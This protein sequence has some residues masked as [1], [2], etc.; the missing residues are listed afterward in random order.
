VLILPLI[1]VPGR[2]V[3]A[4]AAAATGAVVPAP[5]VS[6][7]ATGVLTAMRIAKLKL[8]AGVVAAACLVGVGG[9]GAYSA[10]AQPPAPVPGL[11]TGQ[12]PAPAAERRVVTAEAD[13]L[14]AFPELTP[15]GLEDLVM[16]CPRL[17]GPADEPPAAAKDD[18]L[19]QLQVA[20]VNA[21]RDGL[22]LQLARWQA[23][24]FDGSATGDVYALA[25]RAAEAAADLHTG[26]NGVVE[27]ARVRPWFEERVRVA[28]W[29]ELIVV[30]RVRA[31]AAQ[32]DTIAVARTSRLDAEIAL[33]RLLERERQG[34]RAP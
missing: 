1:A 2:V 8:I 11:P 24:R 3:S 10:T 34:N 23:G 6:L 32:P 15:K 26:R 7:L 31:G 13:S 18:A 14:T 28:K 17:F 30:T 33:L 21:A 19:R 5:S 29:Q 12:P 25:T 4:T 22:K 27:A 9:F 16:N 20:R